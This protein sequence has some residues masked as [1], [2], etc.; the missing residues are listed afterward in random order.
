MIDQ[1]STAE[2]LFGPDDERIERELDVEGFNARSLYHVRGF[3]PVRTE[4]RHAAVTISGTLPADL[5]GAYLRNGTNVPFDRTHVRTHT[6]NGP[7]MLHQVEIAN[8]VATYSNTYV[9]TPRFAFEERAG[10][11][12]F[13]AFSDIA[14]GGRAALEKMQLVEGKKRRGIIPA[15]TPFESTTASTAV[16]F[17]AG[18]IYCL[19]ETGFPFV[20]E[21]KRENG[22]LVLDGNGRL[23]SWNGALK[24]AFAAHPRIDPENGDFFNLGIDRLGGGIFFSHVSEGKLGGHRNVS[25]QTDATGRMAYLHDYFLTEHYLIFPD[26]SLRS[27]MKR[28]AG[29]TG[30]AFFFDPDYKLR[31]GVLPRDPAA[32]TDVRW[33]ET[34]G[35]ATLWHVINGWEETRADG[36]TWIVLYA[37][38]FDSYPPNIPIHTPE[39]PPAKVYKFVLD[40]ATGR[41]AEERLLVDHGY[42]RPSINVDYVGKKN[43]FA[44]LLDEERANGYMGKGV[45]KYDVLDEREAGYFDYGDLYGGEAIFVPRRGATDED[46]GY[47]LD[48]LMGDDSAAL[49]V[50]EARAMRE[51]ARLHLPTRVPFGVHACWLDEEKLSA[52]RV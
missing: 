42:E 18:E 13:V 2:P 10:R 46:D 19:Q 12:V 33:F 9:R 35:A 39:E 23:E 6:F 47:L 30:S 5:E 37:P 51:V 16:Q 26:T 43:R 22:R 14:G 7:G 40:L 32:G 45:L 50:I 8:G 36:G 20:L 24:S 11:E 15:L 41:V 17:H 27:D 1:L 25:Q 52:L 48:L 49:V 34:R 31:W 3:E 44:Y 29:E 28:L 4:V 38:I 21:A